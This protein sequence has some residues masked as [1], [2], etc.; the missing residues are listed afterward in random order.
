MAAYAINHIMD[1]LEAVDPTLMRAVFP[2]A[3]T[4]GIEAASG[5]VDL[6]IGHDN[7]RLFPVEHR[8]VEDAAL[9]RSLFGTGWIASGRPPGPGDPQTSAGLTASAGVR[10]S[11]EAVV[12]AGKQTRTGASGKPGP[13][14]KED[15]SSS[16]K[17]PLGV[18]QVNGATRAEMPANST[19]VIPPV[20]IER[21]IFQPSDFLSAEALGTDMPRRCKN[22]L[23]CKECKFRADSLTSRR[24]RSTRSSWTASNSTKSEESGRRPIPSVYPPSELMD[25]H[26]QVYK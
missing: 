3:P 18:G 19:R 25:H 7:L 16:P 21:R 9:H 22:C 17:G 5:G 8:R 20:H 11:A 15:N 14:E 26:D 6:L 13:G 23:K 24:T 12:G 10:T 2:E 1:P 4:G